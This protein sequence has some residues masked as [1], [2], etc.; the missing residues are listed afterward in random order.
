MR[1][2]SAFFWKQTSRSPPNN[3]LDKVWKKENEDKKYKCEQPYSELKICHVLSLLLKKSWEKKDQ[4]AK[5][6]QFENQI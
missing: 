4:K 3:F 2:R 6:Q 1:F 5:T